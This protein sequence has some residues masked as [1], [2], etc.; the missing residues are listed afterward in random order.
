[1]EEFVNILKGLS[2]KSRLRTIWLL[3]KADHELCVCE[4]MDVL[5]I[6]QYNV[7]RHLKILKNAGLVQEK[8]DGR[9]VFYS[10]IEPGNRFQ[11]F[12]LQAVE[13]LPKELFSLD[14]KR[15][16]KRL[17]LRENGKCVVGI[18]SEEWYK[19]LSQRPPA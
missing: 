13:A 16:K 19:I 8:K 7:S 1:M 12:I 15:L 18:K 10:L 11:E 2:D 4:I 14:E 17:S 3:N 9:W 6:N 5:N